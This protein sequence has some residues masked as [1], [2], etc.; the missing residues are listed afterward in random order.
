MHS[1]R[2]EFLAAGLGAAAATLAAAEEPKA[3][4]MGLLIYSYG[5]HARAENKA[6]SDPVRF[7]S[8]AKSR[9]ANAV[10]IPLGIRSD[11]DAMPVRKACDTLGMSV[12]GIVRPLAQE[13]ADQERFAA[14]LATAKH[15][16]ASVVRTVMLGGRRYEVFNKPEDYAAFYRQAETTLK[17]MEPVA[18][19]H[20]VILAVEN[21][22]DFRTDEL[23]DLLK[24]VSTEWVGV[25]VDTGNNIALLEDPQ[26]VVETLAP[27]ARTVHL[28]D[29]AVEEAE[30][31]FRLAE[32]PL[33]EGFLD[34]QA[35]VT[36]LRKANRKLRFQLEMIT[37]DPLS[38]PCLTENYWATLGR[39]PGRD[40]ART[41]AQVRRVARKIPLPRI[42]DLAP[43]EQLALEDRHVAASF[44]YAAKAKLLEP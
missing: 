35:I 39:V 21:H 9:G 24:M 20:R 37:R 44:A 29:M 6:F 15:C 13:R 30:D 42:T 14:E 32:V 34:L 23:I 4:N 25:C 10:Q 43:P 41:L 31:G 3:A 11:T 16:G 33:G 27:F 17:Q 22:K 19:Q 2:R 1:T 40:L 36:T 28:K 12:E 38:I 5:L 18:R 8:F 7:L 26:R